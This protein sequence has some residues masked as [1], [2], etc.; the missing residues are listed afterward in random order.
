MIRLVPPLVFFA[1]ALVAWE[2]VVLCSGVHEIILPPPSSVA[3]A[4]LDLRGPLMEATTF[5]LIAATLGLVTALVLGSVSAALLSQSR[6]LR[7]GVFPFAV[8]LQTVPI[9]AI[10]PLVISWF[11]PGLVSIVT[12]AVVISMFPVIVQVT[13]GLLGVD[14][15][16]ID[17]FRLHAASRWQQF[18][19]LHLP[20][21]IPSLF[22]AARTSAGLATI[23]VVVGEFFAGFGGGAGLGTLILQW[24][25]STN[26]AALIA[27]TLATTLV[28]V[29]LFMV[30]GFLE[31]LVLPRLGGGV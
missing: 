18:L 4:A 3:R 6:W 12:I 8:V 24:Q 13:A 21:A 7:Q 10:A 23:G 11:G 14:P 31:R 30:V 29:V 19:K 2:L 9:V 28:G 17:L 26:T 20:S 22:T 5:T 25:S 27:A 1:L 15:R 16:L